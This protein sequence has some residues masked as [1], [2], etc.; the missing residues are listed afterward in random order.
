MKDFDPSLLCEVVQFWPMKLYGVPCYRPKRLGLN[1][2]L[3][4]RVTVRVSDRVRVSVI[5]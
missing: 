4:V 3:T 2:I 5:E 1:L